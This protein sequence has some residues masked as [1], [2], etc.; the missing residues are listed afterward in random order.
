MTTVANDPV[1]I[2]NIKKE[3]LMRNIHKELSPS[4]GIVAADGTVTVTST[5]P[6]IEILVESR[7]G[8]KTVTKIRGL[9]VFGIDLV[10]FSQKC[11][12]KFACSASAALIPGLLKEREV[13]I[14][15]HLAHEITIYLNTNNS[16][17][18]HLIT[19]KLLKG[20][21]PKKK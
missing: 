7:M 17:P 21:K 19:T 8:S 16:V 9:E 14:Q 13:V 6:S 11:Q 20:V 12:K 5:K 2:T 3:D 10:Q 1:V 15:G 18:T 4:Y